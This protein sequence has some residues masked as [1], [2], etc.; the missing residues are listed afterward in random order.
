MLKGGFTLINVL[1]VA[2]TPSII[3]FL[4]QF[5]PDNL[6]SLKLHIA[7]NNEK[8]LTY[9]T[10]CQIQLFLVECCAKSLMQI[11]FMQK[12]APQIPIVAIGHDNEQI[13]IHAFKYGGIIDFITVPCNLEEFYYR[14]I[15]D[16]K[17][18]YHQEHL[19][20]LQSLKVGNLT[21]YLKQHQI[22]Q[23]G[24]L[25][26]LTNM[27]YELLLLLAN[28]LNKVVSSKEIYERLWSTDDLI[29][30]S[31]TLQMHISN[32][33]RK[34]NFSPNTR[35]NIVTV[36]KKGYCLKLNEQNDLSYYLP[37]TQ[38]NKII[39]KVMQPMNN[40]CAEEIFQRAI[41]TAKTI[42]ETYFT[43]GDMEKV[44]TY[45]A[46]DNCSWIGWGKNEHYLDYKQF[47][48]TMISRIN[49]IKRTTISNWYFKP[50]FLQDDICIIF[51]T[52]ELKAELEN[53]VFR[54]EH[55]RYTV[56][57]RIE[58][59]GLKV[60]HMHSSTP[61]KFLETNEVYP[62]TSGAKIF[63]DYEEQLQ[64]ISK[65]DCLPAIAAINSPN[66]LRCCKPTDDFA[67]IYLNEA[68]Y[69]LAGYDSMTDMLIH[70]QGKLSKIVYHQD[71]PKVYN[72]M[73]T[74]IDG[75]PYTVNYR[76]LCKNNG[77]PKWLLE[78]G[79]FFSNGKDKPGYFICSSMPLNLNKDE[80]IY[81]TLFS[82]D[83]MPEPELPVEL[84]FRTILDMATKEQDKLMLITKI[85]RLCC[86]IF[87]IPHALLEHLE[88]DNNIKII[89]QYNETTTPTL[90]QDDVQELSGKY[91][92]E[93]VFASFS[94]QGFSQ[95]SDTQI[96]PKQYHQTM[97]KYNISAYLLKYFVI[98]TRKTMKAQTY[99]LA[100]YQYH[101]EHHWSENERDIV[102][103]TAKFL[104]LLLS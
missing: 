70:T 29:Y 61:Y 44:A 49:E 85:L 9:F 38:T 71:L 45:F 15:N 52:C 80:F 3:K 79:K 7:N 104:K 63:Q 19:E 77:T 18:I 66:G 93:D 20:Y 78:R 81:D 31:R 51:F 68:F 12:L 90:S 91:I 60:I 89:A 64:Q 48:N 43:K 69:T 32:L 40:D 10:K 24:V 26:S 95:C 37:Y 86:N 83:E 62:N 101:T 55:A 13:I 42:L 46:K 2:N 23:D 47:F 4:T 94:S 35:L 75:T 11:R 50:L 5:A 53:G 16:I 25:I 6:F 76:V 74:H 34:F 72:I 21:I 30:T 87:H 65:N 82:I 67:A 17:L 98:E 27:E 92:F 8:I 102:E 22:L 36:H 59:T 97:Q 100:F 57:F 1:V 54:A 28:N 39:R 41:N 96:L 103:Q 33:R 56:V 14:L 58:P 88:T 99:V 73:K 84:Y